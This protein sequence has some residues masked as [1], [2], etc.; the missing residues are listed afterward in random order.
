MHPTKTLFIPCYCQKDPL[1]ALSEALKIINKNNFKKISVALTVQHLNRK[2]QVRKFLEDSGVKVTSEQQ[3]IGCRMDNID[4][5]A[6]ACLFIGSGR[7]HPLRIARLFEKTVICANPLSGRADTITSEEIEFCNKRDM[8]RILKAAKGTVFGIIVS[9]K[10]GQQNL[11]FAFKL[12]EGIESKGKK[13]FIIA[14]DEINPHNL[15]GFKVDAFINTACVRL[16]D[17]D[18]EKPV[19]N[20]GEIEIIFKF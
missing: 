2:E 13:A 16:V 3:V 11:K 1:P 5:E 10:P 12:K 17:D 14:G 6:D 4:S 15:M 19:L 18:F 8:R 9:T 7:F 20:P